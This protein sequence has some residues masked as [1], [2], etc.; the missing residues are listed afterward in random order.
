MG[1]YCIVFEVVE[2]VMA[3][4]MNAVNDPTLF[5]SKHV[6]SAAIVL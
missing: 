5:G 6:T 1:S 3:T 2:T 4:L